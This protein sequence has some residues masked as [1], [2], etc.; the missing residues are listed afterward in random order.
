MTD[1]VDSG[2][3]RQKV[4]TAAAGTQITPEEAVDRMLPKI[5]PEELLA[6]VETPGAFKEIAK[7]D[8][9]MELARLRRL[10]KSGSISL[11]DRLKYAQ[12]M[13]RMAGVDTGPADLNADNAQ[14]ASNMPQINIVINGQQAIQPVVNNEVS[15]R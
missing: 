8:L 2:T 12:L 3:T 9:F 14:N 13:A 7:A 10:F 6:A 1:T 11:A 15:K 5:A 4:D